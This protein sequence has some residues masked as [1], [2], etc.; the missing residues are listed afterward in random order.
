MNIRPE[1]LIVDEALSVGDKAF[2][3]KCLAKVNQ[4][5]EEDGVTLLFVTHSTATARQFC[6]RG[7]YLHQGRV[8]FDGDIDM[9]IALYDSPA[10]RRRKR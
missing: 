7:I 8:K 10:M 4:I 6:N 2:R 3:E 5:I 9:A 1:I